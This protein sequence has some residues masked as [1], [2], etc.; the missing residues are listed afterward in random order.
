[1]KTAVTHIP[2]EFQPILHVLPLMYLWNKVSRVVYQVATCHVIVHE[3]NKK[4]HILPT[5]VVKQNLYEAVITVVPKYSGKPTH[6]LA[7]A[8]LHVL[9]TCENTDESNTIVYL[10]LL[11]L[12]EHI[13]HIIRR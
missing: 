2:A 8:L 11:T 1:M 9:A 3:I 12:H 13:G 6:L 10:L 5:F 7:L 4:K